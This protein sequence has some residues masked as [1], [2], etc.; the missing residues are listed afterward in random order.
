[1]DMLISTSPLAEKHMQLLRHVSSAIVAAYSPPT[2]VL[3]YVEDMPYQLPT[4]SSLLVTPTGMIGH[5][6]F[7]VIIST[8][9]GR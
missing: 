8:V 2:S 3:R 1:M 5:Q 6:S 4:G 9:Y 7:G